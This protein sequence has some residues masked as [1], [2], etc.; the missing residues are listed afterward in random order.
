MA[1]KKKSEP[2]AAAK[3]KVS[4]TKKA[5][6]KKVTVK[7]PA[8]KKA[9]PKKPAAKKMAAK[10]AAPKKPAVKKPAAKKVAPKKPVQKLSGHEIHRRIE[11][12]AYYKF[13]QRGYSHGDH[14]NDW[15]EAVKEVISKL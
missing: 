2:A 8:A 15:Y 1:T 9:A 12:A 5:T 4:A 6:P 7:K 11:E 3:G 10:K 14:H 13:V